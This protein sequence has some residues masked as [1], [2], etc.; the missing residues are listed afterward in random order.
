VSVALITQ[1]VVSVG[2]TLLFAGMGLGAGTARIAT[3]VVFV[4]EF[5]LT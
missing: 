3:M 5:R 1:T 2:A 4:D